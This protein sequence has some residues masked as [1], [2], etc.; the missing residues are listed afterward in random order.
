MLKNSKDFE[1]GKPVS[2]MIKDSKMRVQHRE[3]KVTWNSGNTI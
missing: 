1:H 3:E 2:D